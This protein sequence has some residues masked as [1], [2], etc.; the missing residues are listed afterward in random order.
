VRFTNYLCREDGS[1]DHSA[2]I[3]RAAN[4][5][6][7][8]LGPK[9]NQ[10]AINAGLRALDRSGK[11]CRKWQKDSFKVK[12]FTGVVW[13][14]PRWKAPPKITVENKPA[15]GSTSEDSSKENKDNSQVESEKSNSGPDVEMG[16]SN[17]TAPSQMASS[18]APSNPNTTTPVAA[19]PPPAPETNPAVAATA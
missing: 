9:A 5:T 8:K 7:H 14:I 12:S 15:E 11:P 16:N 2:T 19:H 17:S 1:I 10:G 13:E 3:P 18:P 6:A 4:G